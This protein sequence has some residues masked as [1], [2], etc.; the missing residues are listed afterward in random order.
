[1]KTK[2]LSKRLGVER[3]HCIEDAHGTKIQDFSILSQ[4]LEQFA[5]CS[6]CRSAKSKMKIKQ[7]CIS[8]SNMNKASFE[9]KEWEASHADQ[10][11]INHLSSSGDMESEGAIAIYKRSIKERG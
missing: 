8:H 6:S 3:A 4:C 11:P 2:S 1:M 5:I 10:C 9:F 7:A